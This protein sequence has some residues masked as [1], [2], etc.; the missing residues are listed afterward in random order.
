MFAQILLEKELQMCSGYVL[1]SSGTSF[2]WYNYKS[3]SSSLALYIEQNLCNPVVWS[4]GELATLPVI[5][6]ISIFKGW[7]RPMWLLFPGVAVRTPTQGSTI[8][9]NPCHSGVYESLFAFSIN[10]LNARLGQ[11]IGGT[12]RLNHGKKDFAPIHFYKLSKLKTWVE[13]KKSAFFT[14]RTD[15]WTSF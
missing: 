7:L 1:S 15:L 13:L 8:E 9:A 10:K 12:P 14:K 3:N 5:M 11:I 6:L 2:K 4:L